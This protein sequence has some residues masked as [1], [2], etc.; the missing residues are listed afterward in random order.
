MVKV[1]HNREYR[2]VV[3]GKAESFRTP[4]ASQYKDKVAE[5]ASKIFSQPLI[6]QKVEVR[7]NYFHFQ[8]RRM[9]MDN[10]AKCIMDALNGIAYQDDRQVSSQR[11]SSHHLQKFFRLSNEPVDIVKPLKDYDEYAIVRIREVNPEDNP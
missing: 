8:E 6:D 10:V 7:I 2:F 9:D 4:G 3:P 5:I 11:S 1:L